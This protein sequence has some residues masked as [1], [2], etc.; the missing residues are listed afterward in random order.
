MSYVPESLSPRCRPAASPAA[1]DKNEHALIVH[2]GNALLWHLLRPA[3]GFPLETFL[4]ALFSDLLASSGVSGA[5]VPR[6]ICRTASGLHGQSAVLRDRRE[7]G[8][9]R[10]QVPGALPELGAQPAHFAVSTPQA[11]H[12]QSLQQ[13]LQPV[14]PGLHRVAQQ[15]GPDRLPVLFQRF[16]VDLGILQGP[17]DRQVEPRVGHESG[18]G[19]ARSNAG[20]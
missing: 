11:G 19:P 7:F 14:D 6:P 1:R 20:V 10:R 13:P 17:A 18:S 4:T 2:E 8:H 5:P 12:G 16:A 9:R 3:V 15:V